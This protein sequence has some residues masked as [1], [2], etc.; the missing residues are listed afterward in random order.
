MKG[1]LSI[2]NLKLSP[3]RKLYHKLLIAPPFLL[4][5]FH[6]SKTRNKLFH[7]KNFPTNKQT[8]LQLQCLN[9]R[10][11]YPQMLKLSKVM[12]QQR[13]NLKLKRVIK[14]ASRNSNYKN[15]KWKKS[16]KW[17]KV[18]IIIKKMWTSQNHK[19]IDPFQILQIVVPIHWIFPAL[20]Q[21]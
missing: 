13:T 8:R 4:S 21:A 1:Q 2:N 20:E 6:P 5:K 17:K 16:S 12:K 15:C 3:K 19:K 10:K 11:R 14:R 7:R 9:S 18:K